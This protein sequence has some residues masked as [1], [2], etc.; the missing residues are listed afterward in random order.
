MSQSGIG[1]M[2]VKNYG[3]KG[4]SPVRVGLANFAQLNQIMLRHHRQNLALTVAAALLP[5]AL[6]GTAACH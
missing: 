3:K 1:R 6:G 4:D 2:E 5:M